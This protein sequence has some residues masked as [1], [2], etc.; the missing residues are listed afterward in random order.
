MTM[1]HHAEDGA[2]FDRHFR[3]LTV[4]DWLAGQALVSLAT[5]HY[6]NL[7]PFK[8]IAHDCYAMADAMLAE[9]EK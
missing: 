7:T 8:D 9:R 2:I 6:T 3:G 1:P 4:R 5:S